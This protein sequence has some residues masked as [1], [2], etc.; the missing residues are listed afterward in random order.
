MIYKWAISIVGAICLTAMIDVIMS[1]GETK[2]YTKGV[3]SLIVFAV[4]IAP[5]FT[6]TNKN[7][8]YDSIFTGTGENI[9]LNQNYLS[10]VNYKK[11]LDSEDSLE[12]TFE[13]MGYSGVEININYYEADYQVIITSVIIKNV[14]ETIKDIVISTVKS[15]LK[16]DEDRIL[17]ME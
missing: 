4:V 6:L 13:K 5:V 3:L 9:S 8:T 10:S 1:E 11:I 17:I 15:A 16:V 12:K 7:I 14:D 2:K